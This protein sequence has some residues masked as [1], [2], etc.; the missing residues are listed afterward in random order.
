M[1]TTATVREAWEPGITP[2]S[3]SLRSSRNS[4]SSDEGDHLDHHAGSIL[5][6]KSRLKSCAVQS[7][8]D[9]APLPRIHAI[10]IAPH[11]FG[12]HAVIVIVSGPHDTRSSRCGDNTSSAMEHWSTTDA[13]R[14]PTTARHWR[15]NS[16]VACPNGAEEAEVTAG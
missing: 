3:Q 14:K 12:G 13:L 8:R 15:E 9:S 6:V 1:W 7:N 16:G 10:S 11:P 2:I 5:P 4:S